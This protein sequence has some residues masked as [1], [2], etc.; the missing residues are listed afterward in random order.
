MPNEFTIAGSDVEVIIND[1]GL[2]LHRQPHEWKHPGR[3]LDERYHFEREAR[4][5]LARKRL[6]LGDRY[7]DDVEAAMRLW[8]KPEVQIIVRAVQKEG[9]GKQHVFYRAGADQHWAVISR[10]FGPD[11]DIYFQLFNADQLPARIAAEMPSGHPPVP[12]KPYSMEIKGTKPATENAEPNDVEI[13]DDS[14]S[15]REPGL[16]DFAQWP[17][18]LFGYYELYL[19]RGE[20]ARPQRQG[21]MQ[22]CFTDG[23]GFVT[24]EKELGDDKKRLE[25][26]PSDCC[27]HVRNWLAE[28][29]SDYRS[30]VAR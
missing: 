27:S 17:I 11:D 9:S 28:A 30:R 21:M 10:Q 2:P 22:F 1:L 14:P 24:T 12:L 16:E 23:G 18:W 4:E 7:D 26:I 13:F 6:F 20:S 3:T 15:R 8:T 29:I 5:R 25:L 19:R